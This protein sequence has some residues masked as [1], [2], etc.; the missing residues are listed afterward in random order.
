MT[1]PGA[2]AP[3]S[4][5]VAP[6]APGL[7]RSRVRWEVPRALPPLALTVLVAGATF[8][9]AFNG[10][11][12]SL[13]ARYALA[14]AVWWGVGLTVALGLVPRGAIPRAAWIAGGSLAALTAWT[15]LSATWAPGAETAIVEALR[16]CLLVGVFAAIALVSG[17][18]RAD[19]FADGLGLGIALVGILSLLTRLFPHL[20]APPVLEQ[21]LQDVGTRLN[22][23]V[24]YWNGLAM[25]VALG[26]PLWLRAAIADRPAPLRALGVLPIPVA[27]S[28][29]YL[30]S[31]RGAAAVGIVGTLAFLALTNRRPH[32]LAAAAAGGAAAALAAVV[33][34]ARPVLID[35]PLR[36]HD[37]VVKGRSAALLVLL[38]CLGAAAAYGL[39]ARFAPRRATLPRPARAAGWVA[40][41]VACAIG[42]VA[43][44]PG[45]RIREFKR[46][47]GQTVDTSLAR[48]YLEAHLLSSGGAGR[49][50]FW[51]SA[52]D[53][54]Q[55]HPFAGYG[56]GTYEAWWAQHGSLAYFVRDAHSL[57]LETM[58]ELGIVGVLL[59]LGAFVTALTT[60]V[61]RLRRTQW[62]ERATVA[63]LLAGLL[64]FALGAALDWMWEL[65]A[66]AVV[67]IAF[68][69][70]LTGPA[71]L[72]VAAGE[73]EA[74]PRRLSPRL[75]I[76]ARTGTAVAALLIVLFAG[77]SLL[78]Q[79]ALDASQRAAARGD[80]TGALD[81]AL[82]AKRLQP[83]S[84]AP[85]LQ[86]ALVDEQTGSLPVARD[87]VG[88]AIG[89]HP[90]DWR[91]WLV[92][93]R[94]DTK[95]AQP[96]AAQ[97]DLARARELNPRSPLF[98]RG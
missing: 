40:A 90:D 72:P 44:H 29:V 28:V 85:L 41:V 71:T 30:A 50:Q 53:E 69:A 59:L 45:Q 22:Y 89:K 58:G 82:R 48:T 11:T 21:T 75:G 60:G 97:R 70:L 94:L 95:L 7:P 39:V 2:G 35:G 27:V 8:G 91:L 93:A 15:A 74:A 38:L 51:G 65:T 19:R 56:A 49:W 3:T 63:A 78:G 13:E 32:A 79:R 84:S 24:G 67:G 66:V 98:S 52:V 43:L 6:P 62:D 55:A 81:S 17:R 33:I 54:F 18:G 96:R 12:Y 61:A 57:W 92:A 86:L 37:A 9:I 31:S 83:W 16:V 68:L 80:T 73:A 5:P 1:A 77:A 42:I 14:V 10:G 87:W 26:I 25:F 34:H 64:G 88:R 4:Q 36:G 46:P 76:A 23:P 20:V 47:V